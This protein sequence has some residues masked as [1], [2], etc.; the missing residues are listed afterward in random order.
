MPFL[1]DI[2]FT[3]ISNVKP[4]P[5]FPSEDPHFPTPNPCSPTYPFLLPGPGITLYWGI[6]HLQDQW[7]PP[8]DDRPRHPLLHIWLEPWVPPCVF[9]GWWFSPR[10]LWR[11]W[12]VH[13]VVPPMRMQTLQ[14]HMSFLYLL[15]WGPC[16]LTSGWF[17][18]S[19]LYWSGTGG[20]SQ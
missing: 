14:L 6:E 18:A 11:Y 5:S 15:H 9:F 4:F 13:I 19:T 20:A 16:A 8:S 2:F 17:R 12:L 3:Y 10:D 7:S 1:F